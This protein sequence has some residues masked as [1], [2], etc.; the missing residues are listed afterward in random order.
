MFGCAATSA[1]ICT[2][3]AVYEVTKVRQDPGHPIKQVQRNF[4][5]PPSAAAARETASIPE[6]AYS[7]AT[8]APGE[9]ATP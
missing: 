5:A 9:A 3:A 4:S 7:D 1:L 8:T 6:I 2:P